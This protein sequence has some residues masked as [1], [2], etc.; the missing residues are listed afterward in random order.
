MISIH[1]NIVILS[2]VSF[3][4]RSKT[5]KSSDECTNE[6]TQESGCAQNGDSTVKKVPVAIQN[7]EEY[8][9]PVYAVATVVSKDN[10]DGKTNILFIIYHNTLAIIYKYP[11][12]IKEFEQHVN[13]LK[14]DYNEGFIDEFEVSLT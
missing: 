8:E 12:V 9:S 1:S 11:G 7:E 4:R 14:A 13:S 3:L 6:A 10:S 2:L 5:S